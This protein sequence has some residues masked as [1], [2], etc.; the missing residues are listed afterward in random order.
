MNAGRSRTRSRLVES[1]LTFVR[2][3]SYESTVPSVD[4]SE[5]VERAPVLELHATVLIGKDGDEKGSR[6]V[7]VSCSSM[8]RVSVVDNAQGRS[9]GECAVP[10]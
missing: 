2:R 3:G 10:T 5:I 7:A 4:R 6:P 8:I 9:F 1:S